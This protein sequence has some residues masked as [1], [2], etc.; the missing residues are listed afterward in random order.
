MWGKRRS[1]APWTERWKN[2]RSP[3][4]ISNLHNPI[5]K[6]SKG[7]HAFFNHDRDLKKRLM[8]ASNHQAQWLFCCHMH[9]AKGFTMPY[10][11]LH[12]YAIPEAQ[13]IDVWYSCS[14]RCMYMAAY[15]DSLRQPFS[16]HDYSCDR[17]CVTS[18]NDADHYARNQAHAFGASLHETFQNFLFQF[19]YCSLCWTM[20]T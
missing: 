8:R 3:N 18:Y 13:P 9:F 11:M 4:T 10:V 19:R 20:L 1:H 12:Q 7:L 14:T 16:D 15:S 6:C 2:K 5:S 17:S